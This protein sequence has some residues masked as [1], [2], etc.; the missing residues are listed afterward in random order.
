MSLYVLDTDTLSLYQH[1]DPVVSQHVLDVPSS[2]LAITI[3]TVEEQ[4]TGW[5]AAL[6]KAKGAEEIARVYWRLTTTMQFLAGLRI[7]SFTEQAVQ[8]YDDLVKRKLNVGKM[9]LRIAATALEHGGI[10]VTRNVRDFRRIPDLT[11]EDWSV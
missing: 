10:V 3:I 5:L 6:R 4:V 11:V 7:L 9:D 1:G 2:D 8:R